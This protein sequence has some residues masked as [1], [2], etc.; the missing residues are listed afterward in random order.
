MSIHGIPSVLRC[1]GLANG[2]HGSWVHSVYL[3]SGASPAVVVLNVEQDT[4]AQHPTTLEHA[5]E[6]P[7]Q[8][9][10]LDHR[11][12]LSAICTTKYAHMDLRHEPN[13]HPQP[14]TRPCAVAH[15]ALSCMGAGSA[16]PSSPFDRFDGL[17]YDIN[18]FL[19]SDSTGLSNY[20]APLHL[21]MQ[22]LRLSGCH[23]GVERAGDCGT[24]YM[25]LM[26]VL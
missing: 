14:S 9:R 12:K 11:S 17:R 4:W 13:V 1:L 21:S 19:C 20:S 23:W 16:M 7:N 22:C 26:Y 3:R 10:F 6:P 24:P 5:G 2:R 18:H 15:I 8:P 25:Y